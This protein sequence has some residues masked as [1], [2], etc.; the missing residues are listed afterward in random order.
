MPKRRRRGDK[1]DRG[2]IFSGG[3]REAAQQHDFGRHFSD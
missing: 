2:G 1:V 3:H